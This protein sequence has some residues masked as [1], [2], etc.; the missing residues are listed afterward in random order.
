MRALRGAYGA[1]FVLGAGGGRAALAAIA[2]LAALAAMLAA[3]PPS[4]AGSVA[5]KAS[6]EHGCLPGADCVTTQPA[7]PAWL[8]IADGKA[9][10][11]QQTLPGI[12]ADEY[13]SKSS[14]D[15]TAF[16]SATPYV[17]APSLAG[18]GGVFQAT[19]ANLDGEGGPGRT[20]A[21][22][23]HDDRTL[24]V[25][26]PQSRGYRLAAS[27]TV[28]GSGA[29]LGVV[30]LAPPSESGATSKIVVLTEEG[31]YYYDWD[32]IDRELDPEP[33]MP[34]AYMSGEWS[35]EEDLPID[36]ED[37]AFRCG[38]EV[39]PH[40]CSG[41]EPWMFD[42]TAQ[43]LDVYQAPPGKGE[44]AGAAATFAVAYSGSHNGSTEPSYTVSF[45][46]YKSDGKLHLVNQVQED[47]PAGAVGPLEARYATANRYFRA[48]TVAAAAGGGETMTSFDGIDAGGEGIFGETPSLTSTADCP[49]GEGQP[50]L[51][52]NAVDN[53]E[54]ESSDRSTGASLCAV[55][56]QGEVSFQVQRTD[57]EGEWRTV[58]VLEKLE[59]KQSETPETT[60]STASYGGEAPN[61]FDGPTERAI[62]GFEAQLDFPCEE[63]LSQIAEHPTPDGF[64]NATGTFCTGL[65]P[66]GRTAPFEAAVGAAGVLAV[67]VQYAAVDGSGHGELRM[68]SS[69]YR[70]EATRFSTVPTKL[71]G[72][73]DMRLAALPDN[74]TPSLTVLPLD[75]RG[76]SWTA[77]LLLDPSGEVLR[78]REVTSNPT[79]VALMAAPPYYA[80][81]EQQVTPTATAFTSG[82]CTGSGKSQSNSAGIFGGVDASFAMDEFEVEALAK[83]EAAW[84]QETEIE[85]CH[86]FAQEFI[87]GNNGNEFVAENSL[88]FRVET[89][90]VTYLDLTANSLGVAVT[91]EC[92]AEHLAACDATFI[93]EASRYA[94]QTIAQLRNPLP[95][96]ALAGPDR[97][98]QHQYGE[99]LE[100]LL[101]K[102]GNPSSY[103]DISGGSPRGCAGA[104]SGD[105]SG[106]TGI[107]D[108]NPFVPP[109]PPPETTF[110]KA[111]QATL[112]N[113]ASGG[114]EVGTSSTLAFDRSTTETSSAETSIGAEVSVKVGVVK[115]GAEYSHGWGTSTSQGF[116]TG[117]EFSGGVFDFE[118][119][120]NPY[121]YQLYECKA[122][123]PAE[124]GPGAGSVPTPVFYVSYM[125]R[126]AADGL[127]LNMVAPSLPDA[128]VGQEYSGTAFASGGVPAYT[129][130][131]ASGSL[132]P[133]LSLDEST[134]QISGEPTEA[135]TFEF[136]VTAT[137]SVGG[138]ASQEDSIAVNPPLSLR[139]PLPEGDV[140]APYDESLG[141]QGGEAPYHFLLAS[142]SL[143]PG[144]G[145]DNTS[146]TIHGTPTET[147]S[148]CFGVYVTDSGF[149]RATL[150]TQ[151][152]IA[153]G[154]TLALTPS[155]LPPATEGQAYSLDLGGSG[156]D[157]SG[158]A[159]A[160]AVAG[161]C[162]ADE[163]CSEAAPLPPGLTLDPATGL[164]SGTPTATGSYGFAIELSDG[165]GGSTSRD[166]H[167]TVA[168]PG[169]GGAVAP[170]FTSPAAA[171]VDAGEAV[172]LEVT[173][174]GSPA[175][176]L[177]LG[178][179]LP[180]GLSFADEG[181]GVGAIS[182]TPAPGSTG[183]YA[184][185]LTAQNGVL[186]N[187]TQSFELTVDAPPA[188]TAQPADQGT[189][190]PGGTATFT[191]AASGVPAPEASWEVSSD[192]GGSWSPLAGETSP[193]LELEGLE[194]ADDGNEYRAVFSNPRGSART[195]PAKLTVAYA[196]VVEA[197][198]SDV[199]VV[200]G[201]EAVLSAA[202]SGEPEPDAQW[203]VS[204]D[205]GSTWADLAEARSPTLAIAG[206]AMEQD[207]NLYRAVFS[208]TR[209]VAI[210]AAA[211]LTVQDEPVVTDQPRNQT[212]VAGDSASF[213]AAATA[214]PEATVQWLRSSDGGATWT[215]VPGADAPTLTVEDVP[216][217]AD[218]DRYEA[219]F[220]NPAGSATSE[221]A[222]LHVE[223]APRVVSEPA[224]AAVLAGGDAAFAATASGRPEPSL[225]WQV[226]GD[227]GRTWTDVSGA[228]SPSLAVRGVPVADDG[229]LYRAVFANAAGSATS[230]AARLTVESAASVSSQPS[231]QIA[232]PGQ[233]VA[234]SVG[235]AGSPAPSVLWQV[236]R[237][238]GKGW[239]A[240][241]GQA[242][243]TL[244]LA[245]V[246]LK[247]NGFLYRAVV[248]NPR[249]RAVS[250]A[251]TLIVSRL[252]IPGGRCRPG[253]SLLR[254]P[255]SARGHVV[256]Y[257]VYVDGRRT[258][259]V[260]GRGLR[261][262]RI[263]ALGPGAHVVKVV[264]TTTAG[265]RLTTRRV[266]VGCSSGGPGSWHHHRAGHRPAG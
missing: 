197:A 6:S 136:T 55:L 192:G 83:V 97:Q 231:S 126:Q 54:S 256:R 184:L 85:T 171:T 216:A 238:G 87:A 234:F 94:L 63:F 104:P 77:H 128:T 222:V 159:F 110:L 225:R 178:G 137:D 200:A 246:G 181:G 140:G 93:P 119:F 240:L 52:V 84:T 35:G 123:L 188:I 164:L 118:G 96:N 80:G 201:G 33:E 147:G 202:A 14:A 175:P 108:L 166:Y 81:G 66:N 172:A 135:G 253:P 48:A 155:T 176:V 151:R 259:V 23:L 61:S 237:N 89:G 255:R 8:T 220:D 45:F 212:V 24:Q 131:I 3:A 229:Q 224:D 236:S 76:V 19:L 158:Y 141:A 27:A 86:D 109:T 34:A 221:A 263:P 116:D 32:K 68:H 5:P 148:F 196:P 157:P 51:A 218:G 266:Y 105:G 31:F 248:A 190:A 209:G 121:S 18:N 207:G 194:A 230:R 150:E 244:R 182:G 213:G 204:R 199:T 187:A 113:P 100:D 208:N 7:T 142:G 56:H 44:Y 163:T 177:D 22:V 242:G 73:Y 165:A 21:V 262:A 79:P 106:N 241:A 46:A 264:A 186:P 210:S 117:T 206:V 62:V 217:D 71:V 124:L 53:G 82:E 57:E 38:S 214:S 64:P 254:F 50:V 235:I 198:P 9:M 26:G 245:R 247:Q 41:G 112:V 67:H 146:G 4:L 10:L 226:S 37:T 183:S 132:P 65:P 153:V 233:G 133:G 107:L 265:R 162:G 78:R 227:G 160:A 167:L 258:L 125:T 250:D 75:P 251:A 243:P 139:D 114:N 193:T 92:D 59:G 11:T 30:A 88:L 191:A 36:H 127:P 101:P 239:T 17:D 13:G 203:Q 261:S 49:P 185:T 103:P 91:D 42:P 58:S 173:A 189:A 156:G 215:P 40:S 144:L 149:P 170:S 69:A 223:L 249:G 60:V 74:V 95:N 260:H 43:I 134:G 145:I 2:A 152:C 72:D 47:F 25:L 161:S 20:Y 99:G 115:L 15:T 174:G 70:P 1:C 130:Q 232:A 168:A 28:P 111:P 252:A 16:G 154:D 12:A 129:Y 195:D 39:N 29:L 228:T 180:P 90:T 211:T 219:R 120:Y 169:P 102:P 98:L 205:G 257:V 138:H 143:P 179:T 122:D